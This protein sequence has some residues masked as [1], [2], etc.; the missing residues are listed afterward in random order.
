[1]TA[2]IDNKV[3]LWN[4]L[5]EDQVKV[6][7]HNDIVSC[8]A[9]HP[10]V[11]E[12]FATGSFDKILRIWDITE[13]KVVDWVSTNDLITA[14]TFAPDNQHLIVGF[15]KGVVKIYRI[16]QGK[17]KFEMEVSCKNK[18]SF[19]KLNKVGKKVTN[20]TFTDEQEFLVTTNDSRMRL[21]D[22]VTYKT[23]MKYKGHTNTKLLL[24]VSYSYEKQTILTGSEDGRVYMWNRTSDYVPQINPIY[25][26]RKKNRNTSHESFRPF[27]K[28]M[29]PCAVWFPYSIMK[30]FQ[31]RIVRNMEQVYVDSLMLLISFDSDIKVVGNLVELST[32]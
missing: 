8:V 24:P 29:T 14:M 1:L 4:I 31:E 5:N 26:M 28:V 25:T 22:F 15:F 20:I 23:I 21:I 19:G 27:A 10:L 2:S 13:S 12:F 32:H 11:D 17:L 3:V 6:F 7:D 9:F 30:K 16:D 18:F